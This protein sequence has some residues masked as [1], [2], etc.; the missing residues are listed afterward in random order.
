MIKNKRYRDFKE[1]QNYCGHA[2]QS[3]ENDEPEK[4]QILRE[5]KPVIFDSALKQLPKFVWIMELMHPPNLGYIAP[6]IQLWLV[7]QLGCTDM[8]DV[9]FQIQLK[10]IL[11]TVWFHKGMQAAYKAANIDLKHP[12]IPERGEGGHSQEFWVG[13]CRWVL[14]NLTLF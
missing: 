13:V 6:C 5:F 10:T 14:T 9:G 4:F 3:I 11:F 12:I 7:A 1:K 2:K 8:A